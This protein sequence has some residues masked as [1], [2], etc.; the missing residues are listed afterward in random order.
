MPRGQPD[1][2]RSGWPHLP[3]RTF[4]L[5]NSLASLSIIPIPTPFW[6]LPMFRFPCPT[7]GHL[8]KAKPELVGYKS[9]CPRC[10]SVFTLPADNGHAPEPVESPKFNLA[11]IEQPIAQPEIIETGV[12]VVQASKLDPLQFDFDKAANDVRPR[13][14]QRRE[15]GEAPTVRTKP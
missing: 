14:R 3:Q 1:T 5:P 6:A 13:V 7:C 9:K 4:H 2:P 11:A 12:P 10:A 15:Q 8:L